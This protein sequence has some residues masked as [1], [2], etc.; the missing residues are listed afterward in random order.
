MTL[1]RRTLLAAG[2]GAAVGG[3]GPVWSASASSGGRRI[4]V[5]FGWM[6][7]YQDPATP[8]RLNKVGVLKA[9]YAA[10]RN[11]LVLVPG[12]SAGAAYFLPLARDIVERTRGRWQVWA[13]ER[14]ENGLEDHSMLDA[15]KAGKAGHQELFDYYL[16]WLVDPGITEHFQPVPDADVPYAR[17]W[18]M[19]VTVGDLHRVVRAAGR[20][21]RRVVL[22]GHSLGGS[23]VTAY[24]TWDFGGRPGARALGGLV[25]IDGGS[26]PQP[27]TPEQARQSLESLR[28]GTPWLAFGGIGAPFLGLFSATGALGTITNPDGPSL[29]QAFPLLPANLKPPVP[30]TN[31][32]QF[33]YAVD[34]ETSPGALVAAQV[35][36]GRLAAAG[37][38]RGWDQAGEITPLRRY[39]EMLSGYEV[40]GVDGSAWYH[41][42]RLT[43]DSG[44]VAAGNANPAQDV[45]DLKAVHGHRLGRRMP[46]YAFGAALGGQRVLDGAAFLAAQSGI[47]DRAL[48]LVERASTYS[49]NDPSS[50]SPDRNEFLHHLLPFLSR[51][52][53]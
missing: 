53:R 21:G 22:G 35:H 12:T 24:A 46:I 38:P 49:H 27:V 52:G 30:A 8:A 31:A 16:G 1:S 6:D 47:P 4:P 37:E 7:G 19:K 48:T 25:Y 28:A 41:P 2:A 26:H 50:A 10:A 17:G 40:Q 51:A 13:V 32:G 42:L 11:V 45:L 9:G 15:V 39:A 29:G 5:S 43:I 44:A 20:R 18:G 33:G 3:L 23:I 36:A 34:T 14:R